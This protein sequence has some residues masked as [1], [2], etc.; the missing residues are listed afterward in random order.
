MLRRTIAAA[1]VAAALAIGPA[2]AQK[3]KDTLRIGF[4]DPISGVDLVY[5]PKGE[6]AFTANAVFDTL[7]TYN[8]KTL[9][10]GQ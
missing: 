10:F 4:H 1:T 5:D 9:K 8:E 7:I 2:A 3:S 6:T